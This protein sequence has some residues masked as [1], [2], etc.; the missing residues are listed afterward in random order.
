MYAHRVCGS[1]QRSEKELDPRKLKIQVI[2][3][4]LSLGT[5]LRSSARAANAI[6]C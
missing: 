5:R 6:N 2:V 1:Q 4:C 3:S